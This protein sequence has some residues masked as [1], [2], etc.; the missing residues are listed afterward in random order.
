M[1]DLQYTTAL[2]GIAL[3]LA[4][5]YLLRRDHLYLRDG[6]FWIT[7]AA[8]ALVLG[9]WPGIIDKLAGVVGI[10]YSPTLLLLIALI[11]LLLR[12]LLDNIA[13]TQMRRDIRRLNQRIALLDLPDST[14]A[15]RL[16]VEKPTDSRTAHEINPGE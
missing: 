13:L 16:E 1:T 4:I 12:M 6:L 15:Q 7:V 3:A 5:L 10:A 11:V 14:P 9:F 2:L 8:T